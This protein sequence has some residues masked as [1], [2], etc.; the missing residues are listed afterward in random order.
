MKEVFELDV[1][2]LAEELSD[3]V[4]HDFDQWPLK[5]QKT[6][7]QQIIRAATAFR[8]TLQKDTAGSLLPNVNFFTAMPGAPLK[9]PRP[10]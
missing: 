3:R 4:W 2:K 9:R 1:Y 5:V 6:V 8:Q 7:G 10:G